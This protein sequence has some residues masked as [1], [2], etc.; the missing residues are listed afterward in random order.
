MAR[1]NFKKLNIWIDRVKFVSLNYEF[2][3]A[4]PKSETFILTSQM[5]RSAVSISSNIA[6]E[7][8]KATNKHFKAFLKH[9][10]G[11][12]F[13]W[14]IQLEIAKNEAYVGIDTYEK[15]IKE[16]Q[17]LQKR[18]GSFIDKLTS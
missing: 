5:N 9:S 12:A 10:L 13:E 16:I 1:H 2:T 7:S 8:S 14:K 18:I 3:K 15:M 11:S 6:E 4:F 17:S